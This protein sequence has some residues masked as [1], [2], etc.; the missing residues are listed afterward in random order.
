MFMDI[1]LYIQPTYQYDVSIPGLNGVE[2]S[3]TS[4]STPFAFRNNRY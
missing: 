4:C 2:Y 1:R 3:D